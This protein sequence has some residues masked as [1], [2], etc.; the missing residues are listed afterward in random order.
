MTSAAQALSTLSDALEM[1]QV[2]AESN[3]PEV[4]LPNAAGIN[5][6]DVEEL[7]IKITRPLH[8]PVLAPQQENREYRRALFSTAP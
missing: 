7:T 5:A 8:A 2:A 3:P 4:G 6:A 1:Y